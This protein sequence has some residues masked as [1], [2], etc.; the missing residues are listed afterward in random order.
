[1]R[2]EKHERLGFENE[3]SENRFWEKVTAYARTAGK[4]VVEKALWLY[5][6]AQHPGTPA[7]AKS[8]IYGALGY[9][10]FTLDAVPDLTPI[11]GYA[12]DLGVLVVALATVAVYVNDE[13]KAKAAA[14][15]EAWF[16]P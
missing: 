10:I 15:I 14:R 3:Y 12:A 16:G 5:Y 2:K 4:E 9:F 11:A 6:S 7:W 13:I 8:V 1:M